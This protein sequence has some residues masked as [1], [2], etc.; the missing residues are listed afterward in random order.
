MFFCSNWFVINIFNTMITTYVITFI[1]TIYYLL[2][3]FLNQKIR[4]DS[5]MA[6]PHNQS[7]NDI[8]SKDGPIVNK[9]ESN[10]NKTASG[11]HPVTLEVTPKD[12]SNINSILISSWP[13]LLS[14]PPEVWVIVFRHLYLEA[15]PLTTF[16]AGALYQLFPAILRACRL[17]CHEAFE[18]KYR[19][20]A[21]YISSMYPMF[22]IF[23]NWPIR[24]AIQNV[25][26]NVWLTYTSLSQRR[27]S[28]I[29]VIR[30]FGSPTIIQDTF[31]IV[32]HMSV[33]YSN[34]LLNWFTRSL[35]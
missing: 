15:L 26:F 25:H 30:E 31:R 23:D 28:F 27:L 32:F 21:F 35:P 20:N 9:E 12:P 6:V 29:Y 1:L 17:I 7:M 14:L 34:G 16:W 2:S 3:A 22:F 11:S 19:K 13:E 33:F 18:V 10:A 8:I 4:S 24:N 5:K